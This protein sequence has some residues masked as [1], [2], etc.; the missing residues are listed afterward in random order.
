MLVSGRCRQAVAGR[1]RVLQSYERLPPGLGQKWLLGRSTC[2]ATGCYL[3]SLRSRLKRAGG[4]LTEI[5][6]PSENSHSFT[7]G[8]G[9]K[10]LVPSIYQRREHEIRSALGL[11]GDP[12]RLVFRR[13]ERVNWV[14]HGKGIWVRNPD[15]HATIIG[16]SSFGMRSVARDYDMSCL[17]VTSNDELRRRFEAELQ[18][19]REQ[20]PASTQLA[21][22]SGPLAVALAPVLK[23]YM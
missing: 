13:Y 8:R 10:G 3:A 6:S 5:I 17:F 18:F 14:F 11:V 16:S 21:T 19:L 15:Q 4:V 2:K 20:S 12:A 7:T 23:H 9:L 1:T 22:R